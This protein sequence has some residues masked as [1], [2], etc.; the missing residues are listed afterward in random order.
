MRIIA[1]QYKGRRLESVS[2]NG[3]RPT[4]DRVREAVFN[5]ISNRLSGAA[6][7]DIFAGTG[8]LGLEALSRGAD[9]ATFVDAS[10]QACELIQKNALRCGIQEH[11]DIICH[12]IS[13][14]LPP[15][16]LKNNKFSLIFM[17]PPYAS[18]L[19]KETLSSGILT[20]LLT[21]DGMVI[22]E[23]STKESLPHPITGLD[24][25]DQRKYGKT[26]ISFLRP[27]PG[28]VKD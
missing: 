2:V 12:D 18:P 3:I 6:V 4:S 27:A 15:E 17:D 25:H 23:H 5:I 14:T 19:F 24:I 1:G 11:C 22:A 8:A 13:Q 9:R 10:K 7:L 26:L 21:T 20:D 28:Q 16:Q